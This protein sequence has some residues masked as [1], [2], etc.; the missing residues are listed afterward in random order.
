M[1][2][3]LARL[4]NTSILLSWLWAA[5]STLLDE[6]WFLKVE[7][8]WDFRFQFLV[9]NECVLACEWDGVDSVIIACLIFLFL[10]GLVWSTFWSFSYGDDFLLGD[11]VFFLFTNLIVF[12]DYSCLNIF[13]ES[14]YWWMK[15]CS[16]SCTNVLV[17]ILFKEFLFYFLF[18]SM[19]F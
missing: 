16:F 17:A 1:L 18:F 7:W 2:F 12:L 4:G 9:V 8:L 10:F 13:Y 6:I 19:T 3:W 5:G 15:A 11:F 14:L